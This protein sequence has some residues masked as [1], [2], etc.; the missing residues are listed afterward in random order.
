MS[1]VVAIG[2]YHSFL[3]GWEFEY[4]SDYQLKSKQ[5]FGF[6]AGEKCIKTRSAADSLE[7]AKSQDEK[8]Q[9]ILTGSAKALCIPLN[10]EQLPE[11]AVCFQCGKPAT[12]YAV[13]GRSY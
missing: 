13:F 11:G 8:E 12:C 2:S 5:L 1:S 9:L 6:K 4:T 3:S 7:R 10:Q